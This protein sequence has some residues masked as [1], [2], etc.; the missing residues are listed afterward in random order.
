MRVC[1]RWRICCE[2]CLRSPLTALPI[3]V[4]YDE[5]P[6]SLANRPVTKIT[7]SHTRYLIEVGTLSAETDNCMSCSLLSESKRVASDCKR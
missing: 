4:A 7:Q 3:S 1:T 2:L 5:Q 6:Q